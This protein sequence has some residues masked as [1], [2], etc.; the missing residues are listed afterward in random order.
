MAV[1]KEGELEPVIAKISQETPADM[2]GAM[3]SRVSVFMNQFREPGFIPSR[4]RKKLLFSPAKPR[5]LIRLV[6]SR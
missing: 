5:I 1:G 3:W 2:I 4:L 6:M